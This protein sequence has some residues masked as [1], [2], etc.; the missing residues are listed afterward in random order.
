MAANGFFSAEMTTC[1]SGHDAEWPP[2]AI[3]RFIDPVN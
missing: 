1:L 2:L 3:C